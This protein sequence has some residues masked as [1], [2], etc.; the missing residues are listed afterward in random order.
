[1]TVLDSMEGIICFYH[2]A[3]VFSPKLSGMFL[4]EN[5]DNFPSN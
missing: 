2:I 5:L 1:M 3:T 4:F